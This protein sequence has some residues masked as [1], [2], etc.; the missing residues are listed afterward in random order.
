MA[1]GRPLTFKTNEELQEAVNTYFDYCAQYEKPE[2]IAGL[3]YHLGVERK[4]IYNYENRDEFAE[5]WEMIRGIIDRSGFTNKKKYIYPVGI[6]S[7][8]RLLARYNQ[9]IKFKLKVCMTSR[10]RHAMVS[11]NMA[12]TTASRL[13]RD[14]GYTINE[15]KEHLEKL[16]V[17]GMDWDNYGEWHIDHIKPVKMFEYKTVKDEGFKE[18]WALKNLQPLW[19]ADNIRKGCRYANG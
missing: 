9:D 13:R 4:T 1:G 19:A 12:G 10:I 3:A 2:T 6:S 15:L 14:L 18:C 17:G 7:S 5:A 8:D 16:F 11:K